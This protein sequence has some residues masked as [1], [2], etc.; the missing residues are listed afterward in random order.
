M[1]NLAIRGHATRGKEV[2]E[3]LEMLGGSNKYNYSADCDSLCFYIGKNTNIIYYDWVNSCYDDMCVF[4]LEEFLKKFPY[5]VGDKVKNARINDFIGRITNVR[6]D[7]NEKQIIYVVEWD[8]VT[9]S[10]LTY[11]ARGLQ[12]IKVLKNK[13]IMTIETKFNLEQ[14]VWVEWFTRPIKMV[15]ESI[16]FKKNK[17]TE[18][19]KYF[20]V[21]PNDRQE[22]CYVNECELFSTKEELLKSLL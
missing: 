17:Y 9:K 20:V 10:R 11:F 15:I 21:N 12:P 19:I 13:N 18:C 14:E 7:E 2:I 6:W 1:A 4:T 5:K 22:C 8:D 3:I 16:E